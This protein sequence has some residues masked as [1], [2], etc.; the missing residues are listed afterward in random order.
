MAVCRWAIYLSRPW[1]IYLSGIVIDAQCSTIGGIGL[2][3]L[4][5]AWNKFL[6]DVRTVVTY[7]PEL[8]KELLTKLLRGAKEALTVGWE[9]FWYSLKRIWNEINDPILGAVWKI[10]RLFNNEDATV[11]CDGKDGYKIQLN[12][13]AGAPCGIEEGMR[14]HE[15]IHMDDIKANIHPSLCVGK[16]AGYSELYFNKEFQY[17]T[18]CR[19][20]S[21]ELIFLSNKISQGPSSYCRGE[22]NKRV[23]IAKDNKQKYCS[24]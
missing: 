8:A 16:K 20:C 21:A 24:K 1:S 22:L 18:E 7:P 23:D 13:A 6:K 11:A 9:R 12:F 14:L 10:R 5:A 19:A 3:T 17:Y 15:Q 2:G 4:T